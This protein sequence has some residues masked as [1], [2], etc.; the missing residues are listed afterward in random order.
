MNITRRPLLLGAAAAG[1]M[2]GRA[3]AQTAADFMGEWYGALDLGSQRLRLRLVV[4]AGPTATLYSIDQSNA[5][6]PAATT[7]IEADRITISLPA[8][9]GSFQGRLT[10]GRIDGQFTQRGTLPLVFTREQVAETAPPPEALTQARLAALRAESGAPA[11]AAAAANRDGRRIS[12]V[13]GIRAVGRPETAT[14]SDLWHLG[15]IT[16]SMT[17]TLVARGV[18]AG[19]LAWTDTIGDVLGA[20]IPEMRAEYRDVTFRHLCSHRSGLPGNIDM[21]QLMA[22]PRE[23]ADARA[24][25]IAYARLGLQQAPDGPKEQNFTYS[26]TGYVIVGAMIETKIG[27]PWES[28]IHEHVFTPLGMTS[29]GQGAPGRPGAYDQP[30]G[31]E[32]GSTTVTNGQ[33]SNPL[34]PH[35]PGSPIVDNPAALGPAGRVHAS[36]DDVLRYLTAHCSNAS[37]FLRRES[38]DTL[39]T[40]P[41]GGPYAMGWARHGDALWH[42]GSNTLFYA[43]VMFDAGRGIVAAAATNDGDAGAMGQPIGAVLLGAAQAVV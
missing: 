9:G 21:A 43:E 28:L 2:T 33:T 11:F 41:Y 15:S 19:R 25:R 26:N 13:D 24:D 5:E 29:A 10:G 30:V 22:F 3:V 20:A 18:E 23:S 36:M 16:K 34:V 1:L 31:H 39:H 12:Y 8:I 38:W 37:P 35:P 7:R 6:I 27:A 17:A 42:N 4:A 32:P 40:P 14:T